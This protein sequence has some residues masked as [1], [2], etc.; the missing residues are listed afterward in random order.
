MQRKE[1]WCADR[2]WAGPKRPSP[3]ASR[4]QNACGNFD[5]HRAFAG[6]KMAIAHA[7]QFAPTGVT[8]HG[9]IGH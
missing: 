1:N 7:C 6:W 5:D 3:N 2:P 8:K 9:S 4:K